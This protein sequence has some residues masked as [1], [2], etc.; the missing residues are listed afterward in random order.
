MEA[1]R[2]TVLGAASLRYGPTICGGLA[3]YFGERPL[4]IRFWDADPE[5][6][7][8]FDLFA[9]Y[10]FKLNKTPH[11]LLSTE[12]PL[13]AIYGTDRIVVALDDHCA[14][15]FGK[16]TPQE[17]LDVLRPHFPDGVEV[18]DLRGDPTIPEPTEDEERA[19]PHT[20]MR[21][22]RGDEYAYEFLNE[23]ENSPVRLWL[24]ESLP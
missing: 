13:E 21:Y 14:A 2:L 19:L 5:R 8:L 17:A 11:L 22:L 3:G 7:D 18:L 16:V 24:L 1:Q 20:I 12:D 15:R 9:R 4:E 10:L 23:Q 6:L